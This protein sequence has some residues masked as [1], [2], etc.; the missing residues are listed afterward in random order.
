[1][2]SALRAGQEEVEVITVLSE[3]PQRRFELKV[4]RI[5]EVYGLTLSQM[6]LTR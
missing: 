3:K 1:M 2:P 5:S 4:V 6:C